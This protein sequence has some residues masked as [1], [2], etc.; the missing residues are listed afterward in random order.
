MFT[1]VLL[2]AISV[3]C[4]STHG[5]SALGFG[6]DAP[7][8]EEPL[9][10]RHGLPESYGVLAVSVDA[11]EGKG[12]RPADVTYQ[13]RYS[14]P[15]D[16]LED[17]IVDVLRTSGGFSQV[18]RLDGEEAGDAAEAARKAGAS[19]LMEMNLEQPYLLFSKR[20]GN[21]GDFLFWL[22][23]GC[24]TS[25]THDH[26]Y[27]VKFQPIVR[28][29]DLVTGRPIGEESLPTFWRKEE[30]SF[31]ERSSGFGS[32]LLILC[33]FPSTYVKAD[34]EVVLASLLEVS[35]PKVD[36]PIVDLLSRMYFPEV[37]RIRIPEGGDL[38]VAFEFESPTDGVLADGGQGLK[39][40]L[41]LAKTL[42]DLE[43]VRLNEEVLWDASE[44]ENIPPA[45]TIT[46]EKK[47]LDLKDGKATLEIT[48]RSHS[49]PI[50][51]VFV[52]SREVRLRP[53]TNGG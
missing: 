4:A 24:L 37:I 25:W 46:L 43:K 42:K 2:G 23:G 49:E 44:K 3:G 8:D 40:E 34:P 30:L 17:H 22:F 19:L 18:V 26:K 36:R 15:A 45:E 38:P 13:S 6:V 9:A 35:E 7:S 10:V 16:V 20:T 47:S 12:R 39:V 29:T 5:H 48:L 28:L 50:R 51:A 53:P 31:H 52:A 32:Y 27:E 14:F 11:P 41:R 21:F 33:W 1:A